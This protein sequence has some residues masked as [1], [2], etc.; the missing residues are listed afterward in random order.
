MEN[1]IKLFFENQLFVLIIGFLIAAVFPWL[2]LNFSQITSFQMPF[3]LKIF[4]T[5]SS[6]F[7]AVIF[8]LMLLGSVNQTPDIENQTLY[9][10]E[11]GTMLVLNLDKVGQS[12]LFP[13]ISFYVFQRLDKQNLNIY[14]GRMEF[15]RVSKKAFSGKFKDYSVHDLCEG[16]VTVD[17][18]GPESK[19]FRL[20]FIPE[21]ETDFCKKPKNPPEVR[22]Y[23]KSTK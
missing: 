16:N 17:P 9:K 21:K 12:N 15:P 6:V 8:G 14:I 3:R 7:M 20:N 1:L 19:S 5:F 23:I 18:I 13:V 10:N 4:V 11:D 2:G 22:E